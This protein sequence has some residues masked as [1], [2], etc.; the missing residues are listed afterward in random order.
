MRLSWTL[1]SWQVK[2]KTQNL[3]TLSEET[4]TEFGWY[5]ILVGLSSQTTWWGLLEVSE[6]IKHL[7][8]SWLRSVTLNEGQGQ[9]NYQMKAKVNII[10]MWCI[11]MSEA[12]TV[13]CLMMMTSWWFPRNRLRGTHIQTLASTIVNFS[14]IN[15]KLHRVT[16]G[17]FT[18]SNLILVEYNTK[19]AHNTNVTYKHNPKVSPFGIALVKNGK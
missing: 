11:S 12:V 14:L 1:L 9:Y 16:S 15:W 17:L 13:P 5:R 6:I 2:C 7:L 4:E 10:N 3:V 18:R 8:F 19:H